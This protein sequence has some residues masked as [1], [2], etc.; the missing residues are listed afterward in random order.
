MVKYKL[1][2]IDDEISTRKQIYKDVLGCT[3]FFEMMFVKNVDDVDAS[4]NNKHADA[5]IVDVVLDNWHLNLR[6][7]LDKIGDKGPVILVSNKYEKFDSTQ[8]TNILNNTIDSPV[9]HFLAWSEFYDEKS[10]KIAHPDL[11]T[12]TRLKISKELNK[13]HKR[14]NFKIGSNDSI[15][16]LHIS[17]TQFGDKKTDAGAFLLDSA[18]G[19]FL[20]KNSIELHFCIITGDISYSGKPSEY[21]KALDWFK[22]FL[23]E[24]WPNQD[25]RERLL[26][27]PGNH[28][29]NLRLCA[30]DKYEYNFK[31]KK[32]LELKK[33][34]TFKYEH[35]KFGLTPFMKFAYELTGDKNWL[36]YKN[37][38]CWISD[39]FLHLGIRFYHLNSVAELDFNQPE[40]SSLLKSAMDRMTKQSKIYPEKGKRI[41]NI[42]I[43]HHG[44]ASVDLNGYENWDEVKNFFEV[45]MSNLLIHGHGHEWKGY[46]LQEGEAIYNMINIM[47]PSTHAGDKIRPPDERRGFN[48]INL[49]RH[50][51]EVAE[52]HAQSYEMRGAI[53]NKRTCPQTVWEISMGS[54]SS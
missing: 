34:D 1:L 25:M 47:A 11:V 7:I 4:I 38:L 37:N 33:K 2:V 45:N 42:L 46:T 49:K 27:V 43:S 15:N 14:S 50:N 35:R 23:D 26:L 9:I 5:Y 8:L 6:D 52:V 16:I 21:K 30:A 18:I 19:R 13:Y 31:N 54:V 28:D 3:E 36:E 51:Y 39:R 29:V 10:G 41:F 48:L 32:L 24:L 22:A 44:K 20:R 40:K 12:S 53:I 17:D